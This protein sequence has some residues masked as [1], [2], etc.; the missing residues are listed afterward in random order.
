[1]TVVLRNKHIQARGR[2]EAPVRSNAKCL[3]TLSGGSFEPHPSS[4]AP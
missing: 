4:T 2:A 3:A 1:M